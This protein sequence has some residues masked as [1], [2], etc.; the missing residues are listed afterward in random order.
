[1]T[2]LIEIDWEDEEDRP[3]TDQPKLT[4]LQRRI[5]YALTAEDL[6]AEINPA[7]RGGLPS[8]ELAKQLGVSENKVAA[9]MRGLAKLGF[10]AFY[11]EEPE[12]DDQSGPPQEW[13][14]L[15]RLLSAMRAEYPY[16]I[17][18]QAPN[19][20]DH[21]IVG[22][23]GMGL[24]A[25]VIALGLTRLP[26]GKFTCQPPGS[27]DEAEAR[28]LYAEVAI[29][30]YATVQ[31]LR[32]EIDRGFARRAQEEIDALLP[33]AEALYQEHAVVNKGLPMTEESEDVPPFWAALGFMSFDAWLAKHRETGDD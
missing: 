14:R 7:E 18:T 3:M 19:H 10:V 32:G 23:L 1:M 12:A 11:P 4:K 24:F 27:D 33:Q 6:A 16:A 13:M 17:C 26:N 15:F 30:M 5:M 2:T 21:L 9:A 28:V 31:A 29:R 22:N 20:T 25:M 8:E